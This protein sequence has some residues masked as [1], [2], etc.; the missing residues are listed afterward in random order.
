MKI[1]WPV[2]A[3]IFTKQEGALHTLHAFKVE[4]LSYGRRKILILADSSWSIKLLNYF[5][6]S[7]HR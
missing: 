3:Y 7:A 2:S 1:Y 5:I 6:I 4:E